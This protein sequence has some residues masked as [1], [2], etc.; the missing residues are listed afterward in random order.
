DSI[1]TSSAAAST[2]G[3]VVAAEMAAAAA[4]IVTAV[5]E[6]ANAKAVA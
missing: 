1:L 5:P 3:W 4:R 2:C 6:M